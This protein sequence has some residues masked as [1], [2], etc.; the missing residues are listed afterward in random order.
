MIGMAR[1]GRSQVKV[2]S[3]GICSFWESND[4]AISISDIEKAICR[5]AVLRRKVVWRAA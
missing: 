4:S 5:T 2:K 1:G 3:E